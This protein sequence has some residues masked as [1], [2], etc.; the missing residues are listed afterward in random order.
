MTGGNSVVVAVMKKREAADRKVESQISC[1]FK[2]LAEAG[3]L[4]ER[5]LARCSYCV[6]SDG[7]CV[8][9]RP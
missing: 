9:Y 1:L 3:K 7:I 2:V 8:N 5:L 6:P 4:F